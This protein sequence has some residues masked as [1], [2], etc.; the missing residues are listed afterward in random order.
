MTNKKKVILSIGVSLSLCILLCIIVVI[1]I[2]FSRPYPSK[3]FFYLG[4]RITGTFTMSVAG[5]EYN[6]VDE[7]FEYENQGTQRLSSVDSGF[8]IKGGAYGSYK[9]SFILDN[10]ELYR[11]TGDKSFETYSSNPA[12]TFQYINA[13]WWHVTEMALSVEM[14][15]IDDEWILNT[16]V[17]YTEPREDGS[18]FEGVVEK[19]FLYDEVMLDSG[20]VYFG[21]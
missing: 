10:K 9:I 14:I 5:I 6:P 19:S 4:D 12:I 3:Y 18:I 1:A 15:F 16:K 21:L 11:L 13:N 2:S 8:S 7:M 17:V 20:L